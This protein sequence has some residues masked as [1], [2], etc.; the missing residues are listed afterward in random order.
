MSRKKGISLALGKSKESDLN[1]VVIDNLSKNINNKIKKMINKDTIVLLNKSDVQNKQNHK[2][3]VDTV[4]ASVK[5][6]KNIDKLINK[7]KEK[8][9]KKFSSKNNSHLITRER[10]KL[11]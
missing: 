9:S 1:I 5:N 7:I 4:F 11:N 6:N 8:L 2:F 10:H 3:D